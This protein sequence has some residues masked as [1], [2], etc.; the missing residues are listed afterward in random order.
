[1][2]T[3]FDSCGP[4]L[5]LFELFWPLFSSLH[6]IWL[7]LNVLLFLKNVLSRSRAVLTL[8]SRFVP[9]LIVWTVL[10]HFESLTPFSG[11]LR[12]FDRLDCFHH[13]HRFKACL[14]YFDRFDCVWPFLS[15]LDRFRQFWARLR[16]WI[17][18]SLRCI[19][20]GFLM[21]S[22]YKNNCVEP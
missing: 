5:T 18:I 14:R 20:K 6:P 19:F 15:C 22:W 8:M 3:A 7:L 12:T 17:A 21:Y 2:L 10:I 11:V 9:V 13:F 1:M 16:H 4:R